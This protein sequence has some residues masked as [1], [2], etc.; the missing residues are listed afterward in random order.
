MIPLDIESQY[1]V[2]D[3]FLLR[4]DLR[5]EPSM[6]ALAVEQYEALRRSRAM[7]TK[8]WMIPESTSFVVPADDA[9]EIEVKC[10]P[11]A[12]IWGFIFVP[13]GGAAGPFSF[14]V[15]ES[16]TDVPLLSEV[17]RTDNYTLASQDG[18]IQ[19]AYSQNLLP[20]LLI[21]P[22]PGLLTVEI[23]SQQ[24]TNANVQLILCGGEPVCV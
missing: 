7:R 16:C 10:I 20:K 2:R 6:L 23:A 1:P 15:R 4:T 18:V 19:G 9:Y 14:Q 21:I 8:Y 24:S 22:S 17:V 11:G 13:I 12:A 5:C 3:G